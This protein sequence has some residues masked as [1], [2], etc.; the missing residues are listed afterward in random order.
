M[1]E[2]GVSRQFG[3]Q[4]WATS[5]GTVT[6]AIGKANSEISLLL[7]LGFPPPHLCK[8]LEE[9]RDAQSLITAERAHVY[10]IMTL[11]FTTLS[12]EA[13]TIS[14]VTFCC[15]HRSKEKLEP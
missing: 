8:I 4:H 13:L 1:V 9:G 3:Q 12:F 14:F 6:P 7:M 2:S 11:D 15:S 5:H 10:M